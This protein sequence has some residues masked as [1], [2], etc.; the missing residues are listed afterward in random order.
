MEALHSGFLELPSGSPGAYLEFKP[1]P[2]ST[3]GPSKAMS[4][5]VYVDTDLDATI[6]D[7]RRLSVELVEPNTREP[8]VRAPQKKKRQKKQPTPVPKQRTRGGKS[9]GKK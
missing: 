7:L 3:L 9:G 5:V 2:D 1:Q 8:R 4:D 6:E